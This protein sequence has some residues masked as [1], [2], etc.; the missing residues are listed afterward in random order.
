MV[1]ITEANAREAAAAATRLLNDPYL[2][3]TLDEMVADATQ[4]AITAQSRAERR[5]GRAEVLAIHRLRVNLQSVME[6]WRDA[7]RV[8]ERARAHE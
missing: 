7:A 3:E 8:A 6:N 2:S 4:R 5:E 1:E